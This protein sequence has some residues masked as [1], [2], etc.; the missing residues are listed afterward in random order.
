MPVTNRRVAI[1]PITLRLT[2]GTPILISEISI[3]NAADR[4][5]R[6][7][8]FVPRSA[9]QDLTATVIGVGAVGRQVALQL[10]A[11]GVSSLQL[12]DFDTVEPSNLTT[13]GYEQNDLGLPKVEALRT[14]LKRFDPAIQ[15]NTIADRFRPHNPTGE[16]VFC[17]VD[18]IAVRAAIWRMRGGQVRYWC[19][20]RM[21]GETIRVL[22]ATTTTEREYY[23]TTLFAAQEAHVGRCTGHSTIYAANVCAALMVHQLTRWLRGLAVD[24]DL[25]LNLLASELT[26]L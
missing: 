12:I 5:E 1:F 17:C 10:A 24:R 14:S 21:L 9:L 11:I 2:K 22:T 23:A 20:G 16:I 4:F 8:D 18:Q 19:D 3:W 26:V 15:V 13:Q 7:A 6:Q 25:V